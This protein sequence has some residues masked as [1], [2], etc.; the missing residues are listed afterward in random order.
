MQ[1]FAKI[2]TSFIVRLLRFVTLDHFYHLLF[3]GFYQNFKNPVRFKPHIKAVILHFLIFSI[4][5]YAATI[6]VFFLYTGYKLRI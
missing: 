3:D 5:S 4:I 6:V 1:A 2:L